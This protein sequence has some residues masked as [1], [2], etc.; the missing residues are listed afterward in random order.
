VDKMP[1]NTMSYS[2]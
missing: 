1:N 2:K